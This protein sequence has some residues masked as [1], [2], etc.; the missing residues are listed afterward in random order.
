MSGACRLNDDVVAFFDDRD[1]VIRFDDI[2]R[3]RLVAELL[4]RREHVPLLVGDRLTEG[5]RP[6]EI[7]A[8]HLDDVGIVE[9]RDDAAVP[10]LLGLQVGRLLDVLQVARR[11]DD[12]QR[13][14][15]R[16]R[17]QGHQLVRIERDA[18]YQDFELVLA[19]WLGCLTRWPL[20]RLPIAVVLV[21]T[22]EECRD[23]LQGPT[24][25]PRRQRCRAESWSSCAPPGLS[26]LA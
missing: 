23:Q 15:R 18:R 10:A 17:D 12:L 2:V 24:C 8:H 26:K 9:Q 5:L 13:V 25:R 4:D 21:Q 6:V 16:R 14:N 19:Q 7:V 1:L 11:L 22:Q 3:Y 20:R